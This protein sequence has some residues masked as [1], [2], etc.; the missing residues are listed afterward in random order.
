MGEEVWIVWDEH[1]VRLMCGWRYLL[2]HLLSGALYGD[3][4]VACYEPNTPVVLVCL[5][6]GL[7]M[8]SCIW[9]R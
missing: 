1:F 8:N 7:D 4:S 2:L 9:D 5:W 3:D 6:N